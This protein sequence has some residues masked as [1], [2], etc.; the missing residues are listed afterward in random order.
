MRRVMSDKD[1]IRGFL[2]ASNAPS[3]VLEALKRLGDS[4]QPR[5]LDVYGLP[6]SVLVA[7]STSPTRNTR[8]VNAC[9]LLQIKTVGDLLA[10]SRH[11]LLSVPNFGR[12]SL[13]VLVDGLKEYGIEWGR[14]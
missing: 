9:K 3:E 1:L 12:C 13:N 4:E 6:I 5:A 11:E 8:A 14:A 10:R 2:L 7:H